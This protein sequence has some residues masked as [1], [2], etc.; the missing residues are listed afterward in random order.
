MEITPFLTVERVGLLQLKE[1][2]S[3]KEWFG[4]GIPDVEDGSE[5]EVKLKVLMIP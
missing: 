2:V 4:N 5:L 3:I 1:L